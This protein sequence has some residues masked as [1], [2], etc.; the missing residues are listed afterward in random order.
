MQEHPFYQEGS[1]LGRSPKGREGNPSGQAEMGE[2]IRPEQVEAY[3][4]DVKDSIVQSLS[5]NVLNMGNQIRALCDEN[6]NLKAEVERLT[7]EV[8]YRKN[9]DTHIKI[10][11]DQYT[12][13]KEGKPSV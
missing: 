7:A 13:A 3:P 9:M 2:S 5:K 8:N 11:A 10:M 6:T 12:P 1:D 4:A